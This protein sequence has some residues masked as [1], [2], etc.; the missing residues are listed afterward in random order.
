MQLLHANRRP[1]Q[2]NSLMPKVCPLGEKCRKSARRGTN[3]GLFLLLLLAVLCLSAGAAEPNAV[4]FTVA[5]VFSDHMVFQQN[6]PICLWGTGAEEGAVVGAKLADSYG[7][8]TVTDGVWRITLAARCASA[9][10]T[11]LEVFGAADA[12]HYAYE[13]ILI[14]D[15]WLVIGQSNVEYSVAS[16]PEEQKPPFDGTWENLTRLLS[17]DSKDL[18]LAEKKADKTASAL[19]DRY[20]PYAKPWRKAAHPETLNA[21]A[22]GL[23]FASSLCK[24]GSEQIPVGVISLGFAGRELASFVQPENAKALSGYGEKSLIYKHFIEPLLAFPIR[25]VIWY[26]GEANAAYYTEYAEGFRV[27]AEQ[28][29]AD[30]AQSAYTDFPFYIVELPPCFDAPET[31]PDAGWQYTDF[32]MVRAASGMI[33]SLVDNSYLCA[34]SDLWSDRTYRNNLHPNNKPAVAERLAQM[35]AANEWG[36][37]EYNAV[38]APS[39]RKA[40]KVDE[41]GCV[42][43]IFFDHA[44]ESL[45]FSGGVSKGFDSIG[46]D[47]AFTD[48]T[49]EIVA[50]DC[51]RITSSAPIYR[52]R[53]APKTDSV[54]GA[55]ATLCNA[56]GLPACAFY[57]DLEKFPVSFGTYLHIFAVRVYGILYR[58]RLIFILLA[59]VI[60]LSIG[61]LI[62]RKKRRVSS[63]HAKRKDSHA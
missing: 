62:R 54:F 49:C 16:L 56:A 23:C 58:Y 1:F 21:S 20:T 61:L 55:D 15:V 52:L 27:F 42:Y 45:A 6:E 46:K 53:Y 17:F 40:Q 35:A 31:F 5:G 51:V 41:S 57:I 34:C 36:F 11:T 18:R 2:K 38:A 13:D 8:G 12:R 44:G 14:G 30:K 48:I 7:F 37:S 59:F 28:L 24:L 10:S 29:R 32:G 33:P 50:P 19:L 3:I 22:L 47:W 39:F 26:Q 43:D 60:F 4:D 9:E 63:T 25:G